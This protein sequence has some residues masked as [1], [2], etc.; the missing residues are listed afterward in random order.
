MEALDHRAFIDPSRAFYGYSMAEGMHARGDGV[1]YR[2][3]AI[4]DRFFHEAVR[5][6]DSAYLLLTEVAP[7]DDISQTQVV[8]DGDWLHVQFRFCGSGFENI[9]QDHMVETPEQS[10]IVSRYPDGSVIERQI[11][12][13][14]SWKYACLYL[15][16]TT[17]TKLLD[18]D[19]HALAETTRWMGAKQ[20]SEFRCSTIPLSHAIMSPL[21][22]IFSCGFRGPVRRA[23][24]RAKSL[25]ILSILVHAL[26]N[27][28]DHQVNAVK[29]TKADLK[30]LAMARAIMA[31]DLETPLSLATLARRVGLNRTK[32]AQGFKATY[33]DTVQAYWRD[34][35]LLHAR[36][37]LESGDVGV[38]DAA[39]SI[40]YSEIS[41]FTRA[42]TRKF[43]ILPKSCKPRL[44]GRSLV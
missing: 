33:G 16:P 20:S 37:L 35:R 12:R 22:D 1:M 4:V 30:R 14:E 3:D 5:L 15:R 40:G 25:E 6:S 23:Y 2:S 11:R 9:G 34:A 31:E 41:S 13:A 8:G 7:S 42:F 43:G 10:C 21:N 44:D 27:A 38:T 36:S 19:E 29:L 24:M 26:D 17:F 39:F 18:I 32:L 28:A